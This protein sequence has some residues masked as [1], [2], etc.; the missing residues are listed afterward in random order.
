MGDLALV[1]DFGMVHFAKAVKV[2]FDDYLNRVVAQVG[3]PTLEQSLLAATGITAKPT[4]ESDTGEVPV[5]GGGDVVDPDG[6]GK[7]KAK[8]RLKTLSKSHLSFGNDGSLEQKL[9]A[10]YDKATS[11]K[12]GQKFYTDDG[13]EVLPHRLHLALN[14]A[15]DDW[16]TYIPDHPYEEAPIGEMPKFLRKDARDVGRS[17]SS[18]R[19]LLHFA[20]HHEIHKLN[21]LIHDVPLFND[22]M[23]AE[24]AQAKA[25]LDAFFPRSGTMGLDN[26]E[27]KK[28]K[29][30]RAAQ[31]ELPLHESEADKRNRQVQRMVFITRHQKKT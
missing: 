3:K 10:S 21:A 11:L 23:E 25:N 22:G 19:T 1:K 30:T 20:E 18:P 2:T 8:K 5:D 28:K 13:Y 29:N 26:V 17:P 27:R 7:T 4:A 6:G 12:K 14:R 15:K 16:R 31:I 24:K 9:L